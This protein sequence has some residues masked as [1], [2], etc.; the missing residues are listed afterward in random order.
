MLNRTRWAVAA[1]LI[2]VLVS[3]SASAQWV[4]VA[5][6]ALGVVRQMKGPGQDVATVMLEA[7]ADKVYSKAVETIKQKPDWR[8]TNES[9]KSMSVEFTD[10]ERSAKMKVNR[11]E[12]KLSELLIS[13]TATAGNAGTTSLVEEGVMR[14]CRQM[15]VKCTLEGEQP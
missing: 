14:V 11:I 3:T 4:F 5:R 6:K 12:Q 10:G 1:L 9:A 15:N 13:S 2:S 8:I 7:P